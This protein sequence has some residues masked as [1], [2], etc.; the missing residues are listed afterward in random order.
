MNHRV[1]VRGAYALFL[2]M[3]ISS[4]A[5]A[6]ESMIQAFGP[7]T[8]KKEDGKQTV[9][10]SPA[11]T[12]G[13]T[14]LTVIRGNDQSKGD[15]KVNGQKIVK[16]KDFKDFIVVRKEICLLA[17]NTVEVK[18]KGP[19][20]GSLTVL[21]TTICDSE[22][23]PFDQRNVVEKLTVWQKTYSGHAPPQEDYSS[24]AMPTREGLFWLE[25]ENGGV[26][27]QKAK[28]GKVEFNY[29]ES[30]DLK[31][32]GV[33][34]KRYPITPK[35]AN[36]LMMDIENPA[37]AQV[38][39]RLICFAVTPES[40]KTGG[41]ATLLGA[42]KSY[43]LIGEAPIVAPDGKSDFCTTL[44][45]GL[46]VGGGLKL[47]IWD[48]S[49][50]SE[51]PDTVVPVSGNPRK[52][53]CL[54]NGE[55]TVNEI[56][57]SEG[58]GFIE[59]DY[60]LKIRGK[61]QGLAVIQLIDCSSDNES[62]TENPGVITSWCVV[63]KEYGFEI[64]GQCPSRNCPSTDECG[65]LGCLKSDGHSLLISQGLFMPALNVLP[66]T[67]GRNGLSPSWLLRYSS[68]AYSCGGH[69][70]RTAFTMPCF[71]RLY[72]DGGDYIYQETKVR[73]FP[74]ST[75]V[76]NSAVT[77]WT[78]DERYEVLYEF[79]G[80]VYL[81]Q[82]DGTE[83]SFYPVSA[84]S[85]VSGKLYQ[86]TNRFGDTLTF[87]YGSACGQLEYIQDM[88]GRRWN[89]GWDDC[90]RVSTITEDTTAGACLPGRSVT[91][92]YDNDNR[93]N[94]VKTQGVTTD[95]GIGNTFTNKSWKY[96]YVAWTGDFVLDTNIKSITKPNETSLAY[97]NIGYGTNPSLANYD[98]V[99]VQELGGSNA[100][101]R[102]SGGSLSYVYD[103][104]IPTAPKT[105][106]TDRN[107]NQTV[108][109][110]DDCLCHAV[111]VVEKTNR[112]VR[113]GEGDY[114]TTVDYN[115]DGEITKI[116]YP[117]GNSVVYSYD[118]S[119]TNRFAHGNLLSVTRK[120]GAGR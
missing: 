94:E 87:E 55:E 29:Y 35:A 105:T 80:L 101:G 119:N 47:R 75:A 65:P 4:S 56:V 68:R 52:H 115:S 41:Q 97:V 40:S 86:I 30:F 49:L 21:I 76:S 84:S 104:S 17:S 82:K 77:G 53:A 78:A 103:H 44:K 10:F 117:E 74:F 96:G 102:G 20:G 3:L 12:Q 114:T 88:Y 2:G 70:G 95:G 51:E 38:T 85:Y 67:M 79:K 33:G 99:T 42:G 11:T 81:R 37:A 58:E 109:T 61:K 28:K 26:G 91:F 116:T 5:F 24:V 25:V 1:M 46:E 120:A 73:T 118:T 9:T 8:F 113:S 48:G 14:Y 43:A 18:P 60:S 22:H 36:S 64:N 50:S 92:E 31:K 100:S 32:H 89:F 83:L 16:S 72:K 63:V 27:V 7:R 54:F 90:L 111:T 98:R 23:L 110:F 108:Y 62:P 15:V 6:E 45:Y 39:L 34:T 57:I 112:N 19:N 106:V 59:G 93:M 71:E 13:T 66:Y 107:S 69:F